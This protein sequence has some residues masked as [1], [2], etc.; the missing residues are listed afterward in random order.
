MSKL[1]TFLTGVKVL[2]L[3]QYIPGP[4]ASLYLADMGAE[5][6]KIEPPQ[7]DPMRLLGPRD[8]DGEAVFHRA[9]N[10]GKAIR[11]M[12]L[13][14]PAERDALLALLSDYDVL[15]EGFRPGVMARLGLDYS[16]I[17]TINPSLI[18]CSIS[19]YGATGSQA[20]RPAHDGNYLAT[21]GIMHRNGTDRP[22]FYDPPLSDVTG[23]LYALSAIL[24]AL[25]RRQ[26]EGTG[27]HIDLGLADVAM[28]IQMLQIA[29]WGT[30]RINP[31][32]SE[33]YL[34]GGAAYY[35]VYA[36][37]DG[38]YI[39]LGAVEA[40]F[41]ANFCVLAERPN[42]IVRHNEPLPQA[43]LIADLQSYFVT[44]SLTEILA[45]FGEGECCLSPIYDLDGALSQK[46]LT[47]R[48]LVQ[49]SAD[50]ELQAL[51]PVLIDGARPHLRAAPA[52]Y[53]SAAVASHPPKKIF[54]SLK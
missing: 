2:D 16:A 15:I 9:L 4:M 28:P 31:A 20:Q 26:Q 17:S 12:N 45:L 35:N 18:Y 14:D 13:K 37:R 50:G 23:S 44:Q 19:G 10:S 25:Y 46:H 22:V 39:M 27:C 3:S 11:R 30:D 51:F 38:R 53:H 43:N 8:S 6:L 47:E 52:D 32:R 34:N 24:G 40:K 7:G 21:S 29:S 41:W 1:N 48:G 33:T 36:T 5:V 42:W 54:V 49:R